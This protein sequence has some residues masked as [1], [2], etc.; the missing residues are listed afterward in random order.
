ML[1]VLLGLD[2]LLSTISTLVLTY[3]RELKLI[4]RN[5]A[6]QALVVT[7]RPLSMLRLLS[8]FWKWKS[9]SAAFQV[10]WLDAPDCSELTVA[11]WDG[12]TGGA[13]RVDVLLLAGILPHGVWWGPALRS[14]VPGD[15]AEWQQRRLLHQSV[16]GVA[17]SQYPAH[18]FLVRTVTGRQTH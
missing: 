18:L 2:C 5:V 4:L 14:P 3:Q 6:F 11:A 9:R 7:P 15:S 13:L 8:L 16:P 10:E 17:H 1:S 12:C